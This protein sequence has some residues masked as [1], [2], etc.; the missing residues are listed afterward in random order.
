M[1]RP[2]AVRAGS[3]IESN[4]PCA[5]ALLRIKSLRLFLA[6]AEGRFGDSL[7][8]V[9]CD[10]AAGTVTFRVIKKLNRATSGERL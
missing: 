1:S 9:E 10:P 6:Q 4:R 8:G 5:C 3:T 2:R 7:P